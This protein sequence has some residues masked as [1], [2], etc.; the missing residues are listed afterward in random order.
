MKNI[1]EAIV[2]I[3]QHKKALELSEG[4]EPVWYDQRYSLKNK[5][6]VLSKM[7]WKNGV[8]RVRNKIKGFLK[9]LIR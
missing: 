2:S 3:I 8:W 5:E 7:I 9:W 4:I 1:Y 6:V